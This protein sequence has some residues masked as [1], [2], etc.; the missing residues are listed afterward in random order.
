MQTETLAFEEQK[1]MER[2]YAIPYNWCHKKYTRHWRGKNGLRTIVLRLLGDVSDKIVLDAGC[3]DGWY[4]AKIADQARQTIGIDFSERS[5]GFAR[6]IVPQATFEVGSIT[7]IPLPPESVDAL[8]SIQVIEHL[9]PDQVVQ[10]VKELARVLRPNGTAIISVP[11]TV[12]KMSTA[13]FQ[14]FTPHSLRKIMTPSFEIISMVG[15][16]RRTWVLYFLEK[17]IENRLWYLPNIGA[18]FG[19]GAFLKYWNETT[20]ERGQNLVFLCK[21]R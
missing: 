18:R 7:N 21:K 17:C 6:L 4:T 11:S 19:K 9:P 10:A 20:A 2:R 14:H 12:R 1:V 16:E 5:V 8:V 3:G 13:H 15:Q